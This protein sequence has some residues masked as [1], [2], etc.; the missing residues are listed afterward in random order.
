MVEYPLV[1]EFPHARFEIWENCVKTI[2]PD[3]EVVA[4]PNEGEDLWDTAIHEFLHSAIA[5]V[6]GNEPSHC[7][8]MVARGEKPRWNKERGYEETLA[9]NLGLKLKELFVK[10]KSMESDL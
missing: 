5:E 1:I 4:A 7:L 9:Y 2:L 10:L 3:G 6:L 8:S